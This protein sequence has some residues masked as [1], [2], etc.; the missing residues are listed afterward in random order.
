MHTRTGRQGGN[1]THWQV[2]KVKG[3]GLTAWG[4]VRMHALVGRHST[5]SQAGSRVQW[6]VEARGGKGGVTV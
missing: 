5:G 4:A 6:Q 3:S 2:G 1:T